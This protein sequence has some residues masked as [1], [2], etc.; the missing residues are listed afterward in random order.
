[1]DALGPPP[2]TTYPIHRPS[3]M[4]MVK[5]TRPPTQVTQL[6]GCHVD[7]REER[8]MLALQMMDNEL[9]IQSCSCFHLSLNLNLNMNLNLYYNQ[10]SKPGNLIDAHLHCISDVCM[11]RHGMASATA[12][13]SIMSAMHRFTGNTSALWLRFRSSS[14]ASAQTPS[15]R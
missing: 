3:T 8:R 12:S 7:W 4:V 13:A 6:Y 15:S 9:N 2:P 11:Q 10:T 5:I 1:M 14:A